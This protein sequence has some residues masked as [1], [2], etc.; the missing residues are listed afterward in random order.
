MDGFE[1]ARLIKTKSKTSRIKIIALTASVR[2]DDQDEDYEKYFDGYLQKPVSRVDLYKELMRFIGYSEI[3]N[4]Q[5]EP[6]PDLSKSEHSGELKML[7][8]DAKKLIDELE[9]HLFTM[10]KTANTYQMSDEI[11]IF[12]EALI[13][14]GSSYKVQVLNQFGQSLYDAVDRFDLEAMDANLKKYPALLNSL[15]K[16]L[17]DFIS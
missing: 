1:A 14:A 3:R 6:E 15:K 12:S 8:K 10:W 17:E 11:E 16:R 2:S 13:S 9:G 4:K 5:P 7:K